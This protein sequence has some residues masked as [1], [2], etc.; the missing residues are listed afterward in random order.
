[1]GTFKY[2]LKYTS[3]INNAITEYTTGC[4]M[5]PDKRLAKEYARYMLG[6]IK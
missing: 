4:S 6:Q 5:N 3:L 1:M 2:P